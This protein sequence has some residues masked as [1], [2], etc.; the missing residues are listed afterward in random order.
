[1]KS[2]C[3]VSSSWFI[4]PSRFLAGVAAFCLL[5]NGLVPRY[6]ISAHNYNVLSQV[7]GVQAPLMELFSFSAIPI[8]IVGQ[9]MKDAAIA[10]SGQKHKKKQEGNSAGASTDFSIV[11][12]EMRVGQ[13]RCA[14][15]FTAGNAV[16]SLY[17]GVIRYGHEYSRPLGS[18]VR[19]P[20]G[21][22]LIL[23]LF[24]FLLPRSGI[25]DHA[26]VAILRNSFARLAPAI[27]VF[28]C[29]GGVL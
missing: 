27:R 24:F 15:F 21:I 22:G 8:K 3:A 11:S 4:S 1:M 28:Y 19:P 5:I 13:S 18:P 29:R 7:I 2:Y 10:S 26:L 14:G 12:G 25:D 17:A 16:F 23:S 9:L 20:G 6:S